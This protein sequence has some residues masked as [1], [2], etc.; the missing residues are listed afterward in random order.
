MLNLEARIQGA[1]VRGLA[2]CRSVET[3]EFYGSVCHFVWLKCAAQG[4]TQ[5]RVSWRPL[6]SQPNNPGNGSALL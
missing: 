3:I 2:D 6:G 1:Q 5:G 4:E